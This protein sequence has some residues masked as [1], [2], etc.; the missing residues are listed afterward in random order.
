[1]KKIE[2][3]SIHNPS[4]NAIFALFGG[5][6]FGF[7]VILFYAA[8]DFSYLSLR[9][10]AS[11][12]SVAL[13]VACS[14][15]LS[16]VLLG[17]LFAIPR[18]HQQ[19]G[20]YSNK[21]KFNEESTKMDQIQ[22]VTYDDNTNLEQISDWL[23]KILVGV[24]LTQMSGI[25][26]SLRKYAIY[27]APGLGGYKNSEVFS[28]AILLFFLINGFLISYLWTRIYFRGALSDSLSRFIQ[29]FEKNADIDS[30]A[31]RLFQEIVTPAKD[32]AP[33]TQKELNEI[34]A[35]ASINMR[36]EIFW[37][38]KKIRSDNWNIP[39]NKK[40]ER[41]IPIF[42]ALIAADPKGQY[43]RNHGEL[44]F[45][46][47]DKMDPEYAEALMEINKAID[48]RGSLKATGGLPYYELVRAQCRIK[49]DKAF[50][51]DIVSDENTKQYILD[52]INIISLYPETRKIMTAD[53]LI[54]S[55]M[56]LNNQTYPC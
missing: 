43:H 6:F 18:T 1:M 26:D 4:F 45:A 11:V 48:L 25:S 13:L 30:K 56:K 3:K 37:E 5:L 39:D 16:G 29:K 46:L 42:R 17:F 10:Y 53:T 52:D 14:A 22:D 9:Q 44:G 24:G 23:T 12:V 34:I 28:V 20:D 51:R 49:L 50:Q 7:I 41:M 27:I 8:P 55:W 19:D 32:S 21:K 15:S 38:A 33:P 35:K 40:S 47:K 54:N 31:W 36:A 2:Y